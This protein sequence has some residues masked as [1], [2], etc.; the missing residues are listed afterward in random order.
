LL[1]NGIEEAYTITLLRPRRKYELLLFIRNLL[2]VYN[3][4]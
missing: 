1:N 2:L 3:R 4:G